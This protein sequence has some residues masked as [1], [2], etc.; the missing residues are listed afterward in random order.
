MTKEPKNLW[1]SNLILSDIP[2]DYYLHPCPTLYAQELSKNGP[3]LWVNP[4]TRNPIKTRLIFKNKN[5]IILTPII[6]KRSSIDSGFSRFEVRLQIKTIVSIFLGLTSSVWSIS[7]AYPHLLTENP[8]AKSIFWSGDFFS[9]IEEFSKYKNFDLILCLTPLKYAMVPNTFK[10]GKLDF[11]MCTDSTVKT[12]RNHPVEIMELVTIRN[13]ACS[14]T[15]IAG[16]VGTLSSRRFDFEIFLHAVTVL[17]NVLF[18]VIGKSDGT[19][20]TERLIKKLLTYKNILFIDGMPYENIHSAI[21]CFD[22]CLIPYREDFANLG[23]CPTK[24][25]DYCAS[26]KTVLSTN[27]PGLQKFGDLCLFANDKDDF[28]RLINSFDPSKNSLAKDRI[29]L[30]KN[31][32]PDHFLEKFQSSFNRTH[33]SCKVGIPIT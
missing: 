16:Y 31:S 28:C 27:L 7:T 13:K 24:F 3:T 20:K 33:K 18:V 11:H 22:I 29:Q 26:G 23:T 12:S 17:K 8:N 6:F 4:P 25:I 5:L 9:P 14:F 30:S 2:W 1:N 15:K 10:G 21:D 32:S 19:Q